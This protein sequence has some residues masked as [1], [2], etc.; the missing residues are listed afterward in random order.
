MALALAFEVNG[1]E[2]VGSQRHLWVR[3]I[4]QGRRPYLVQELRLDDA[5][6]ASYLILYKVLCSYH[7]NKTG[8]LLHFILVVFVAMETT[9]CSL[10]IGQLSKRCLT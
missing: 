5:R 2:N 3:D 6:F 9:R 10:V 8:H 1:E 7:T 4:I